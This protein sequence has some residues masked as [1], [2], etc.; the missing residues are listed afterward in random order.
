[1][2]DPEANPFL[3][4]IP[5]SE[6]PV[7]ECFAILLSHLTF[8]DQS[9]SAQRAKVQLAICYKF[10]EEKSRREPGWQS[11][12]QK[13]KPQHLFF[14]E[15]QAK[16]FLGKFHSRYDVRIAASCIAYPY[17]ME[18]TYNIFPR[19]EFKVDNLLSIAR[20]SELLEPNLIQKYSS[21]AHTRIWKPSIPVIHLALSISMNLLDLKKGEQTMLYRMLNN[22]VFLKSVVEASDLLAYLIVRSPKLQ[23]SPKALIRSKALICFRLT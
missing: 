8:P 11:S 16:K 13:I 6:L 1:M 4:Q 10:L 5:M 2:A 9:E 18:S 20:M 14:P 19:R 3:V 21:N 15:K 22:G 23:Q 7:Y 17:L 12:P